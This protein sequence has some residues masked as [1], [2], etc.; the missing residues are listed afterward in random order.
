MTFRRRRCSIQVISI[1]V[2][3]EHVP[4]RSSARFGK[5]SSCGCGI[6]VAGS[7][8]RCATHRKAANA[9]VLVIMREMVGSGYLATTG[10]EMTR[11]LGALL[12][13]CIAVSYRSPTGGQ[14]GCEAASEAAMRR[15]RC[16]TIFSRNSEV[17]TTHKQLFHGNRYISSDDACLDA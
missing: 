6:W 17:H 15:G 1:R 12:R 2:N 13:T 4:L 7:P 10:R 16:P 9:V 5:S 11:R 3:G 8:P 14:T